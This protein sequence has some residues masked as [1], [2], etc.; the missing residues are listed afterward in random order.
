MK[1]LLLFILTALLCLTPATDVAAASSPLS[2]TPSSTI[3]TIGVLP[4]APGVTDYWDGADRAH[5][6]ALFG[7]HYAII[8]GYFTTYEHKGVSYARN[9]IVIIDLQ[10]GLPTNVTP[11]TDGEILTVQ[12]APSGNEAYIGGRFRNVNNTKRNYAA[13]INL[14]TGALLDWNPNL[15]NVVY[16]IATIGDRVLIGGAFTTVG[17]TSREVLAS[18]N[19]TTGKLTK[20]LKLNITGH[21]SASPKLVFNIIVSPDNKAILVTGNFYKVNGNKH[22]RVFLIKVTSDGPKLAAWKTTYT[23]KA[24][25]TTKAYEELGAT[26]DAT[27]DNFYLATTGGDYK[28]SDCDATSKWDARKLGNTNAKP[29]WINY[30]DRDSLSGIAVIGN[31]VFV[32]GHQKACALEAGRPFVTE[33][34]PGLCELNATTGALMPWNPTT[35]RQRSMHVR[36]IVTPQGMLYVGDANRIGGQLR[37]DLALFPYAQ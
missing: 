37:N 3:G 17:G 26:F 22:H 21:A 28:G 25:A 24:C 9:N 11:S 36:L 18:V 5:G 34:R 30:T 8:V 29:V 33:A 15:N 12:I 16:D 14:E 1:R 32:A 10:T 35:S 23:E 2:E 27:G 20:W 31:S 19:D 6:A 13:K 4:V 7:G